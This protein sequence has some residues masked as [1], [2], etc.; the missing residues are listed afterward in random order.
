M[1]D[2][3]NIPYERKCKKCGKII[4]FLT[5]DPA[6]WGYRIKDYCFCSYSC[7]RVFEKENKGRRK[8]N[9]VV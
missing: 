3:G 9:V 7:M 2:C 4:Y 6:R 1:M 5:R 8:H